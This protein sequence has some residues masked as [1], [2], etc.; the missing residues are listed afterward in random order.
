M[1]RCS[2]LSWQASLASAAVSAAED[3]RSAV[4]VARTAAGAKVA[5]EAAA[6]R[7]QKARDEGQFSTD[8]EAG[9]AQTRASIA[10]GHATHAAVIEHEASAARRRAALALAHDVRVWNVHRK[11]GLL[12]MCRAVARTQREACERSA[13]AW[14]HLRDGLVGSM[15]VPVT[16]ERRAASSQRQEDEREQVIRQQ[17]LFE[18]CLDPPV[19]NQ[20]EHSH[21]GCGQGESETHE[22]LPSTLPTLESTDER[23]VSS[24][25]KEVQ[26]KQVSPLDLFESSF[27]LPQVNTGHIC[28]PEIFH[29]EKGPEEPLA[30]STTESK[31]AEMHNVSDA[32]FTPPI[33]V[34]EKEMLSENGQGYCE[35]DSVPLHHTLAEGEPTKE[36][37][38]LPTT[39][40]NDDFP[41]ALSSIDVKLSDVKSSPE[42]DKPLSK[43]EEI[44]DDLDNPF[45]V[46]TSPILALSGECIL[47]REEC[48]NQSI[49]TKE[50]RGAHM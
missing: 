39:L 22:I 36:L 49:E 8:A 48:S 15:F 25:S 50:M 37:L 35:E 42:P 4:R 21:F 40:P 13:D 11:R 27:D 20:R 2:D 10:R 23:R 1:D 24:F 19:V 7:A 34:S 31:L 26:Q 43:K 3:V 12:G 32:S 38:A 17:D 41:P 5:A 47:D 16:D 46:S 30:R 45:S 28:D 33:D 9:A 29:M 6:A 18:S 14:A 44:T